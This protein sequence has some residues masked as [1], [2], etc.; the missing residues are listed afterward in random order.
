[1][2]ANGTTFRYGDDWQRPVRTALSVPVVSYLIGY[3][4]YLT[5]LCSN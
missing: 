3:L 1:M 4:K 2:G 5:S